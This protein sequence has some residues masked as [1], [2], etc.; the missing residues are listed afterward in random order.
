MMTHNSQLQLSNPTRTAIRVW[1]PWQEE[2]VY[3]QWHI[4]FHGIK[5]IKVVEN[6]F[7]HFLSKKSFRDLIR[8]AREN[9][10]YDRRIL[11]KDSVYINIAG[12]SK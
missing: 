12:H 8:F 9:D 7:H 6:T 4:G 3:T 11:A 5:S 1:F 10:S 2:S